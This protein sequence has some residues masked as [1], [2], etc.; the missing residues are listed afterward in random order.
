M[1]AVSA[2]AV[3]RR[4]GTERWSGSRAQRPSRLFL[5]RLEKCIKRHQPFEAAF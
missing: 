2:V 4:Y 5:N 3:T 1:I